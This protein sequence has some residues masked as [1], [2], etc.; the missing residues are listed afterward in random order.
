M[1]RIIK[2]KLM[3]IFITATLI[4]A[5]VGF[6]FANRS[7][8]WFAINKEVEAH[9]FSVNTKVSSNLIIGKSVADITGPNVLFSVNFAGT[10][11]TDMIAVTHDDDAGS[12]NLKYLYNH[13][14]VGHTTGLAKPGAMLEFENVPETD[15]EAYFID[16]VVYIASAFAPLEASALKA[17][18]VSPVKADSLYPYAM[19][20]SVDFYV[21]EVTDENYRG[22]TSLADNVNNSENE[23]VELLLD[24]GETIPLAADGYLTVTMRCYFDG[25]L[26]TPD[27]S[28][29]YVNSYEVNTNGV[30]IGVEF[31]AIEKTT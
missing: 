20:A 12:T 29:A 18:V 31:T 5:F 8:A 19:A 24:G 17:T 15:N 3:L 21:G 9:G 27:G 25:A 28:K 16:Y 26:T 4:V 14:A 6:L 30:V 7:L 22:T 10:A 13:Y 2:Q 1:S 23:S 11:R